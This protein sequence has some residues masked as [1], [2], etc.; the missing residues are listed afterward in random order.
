MR[1]G[2]STHLY[3]ADRLDR[4][5]L[6]EIAAHDFEAVEVFATRT[7][8]DYHDPEAVTALAEWL[9][10]TRLILS[11]MH[12]P[13]CAS[14]VDGIWG[15]TYST[16]IAD[17]GRRRRALA[18]TEAALNVAR[19]IP[20]PFLVVHLG[21]PGT[22]ARGDNS[23]DA[24]RRSLDELQRMAEAVN[25]RVALEV[26]P[27][28]LSAATALVRLIEEELDAPNLGICLDIGHARL[29]GDP[30]DAIEACSGHLVTTHLHDNQGR[31]DDHLVPFEGIIDWEAALLALQKIG[32]EGAWMF[33][34]ANT[35]STSSV[36]E[37]TSRA[38]RRFE[39]LLA[40]RLPD[41]W[42]ADDADI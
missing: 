33:E 39:A 4:E 30:I 22:D 15:E 1:F 9:D 31:T 3:H 37:R 36:L 40:Q 23:R 42:S 13:I 41:G 34:V 10:D 17:D 14:L 5:H 18:E 6:V 32:Y 2:L 21:V 11:S 38:R 19:T 26:I 8:F 24:A 16:A 29:M 7:H 12:A 35:G 25:V 20:Y 27:N 28:P